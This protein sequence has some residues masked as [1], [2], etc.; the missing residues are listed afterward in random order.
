MVARL[1]LAIGVETGLTRVVVQKTSEMTDRTWRLGRRAFLAVAGATAFGTLAAGRALGQSTS[2]GTT[3]D[4]PPPTSVDPIGDLAF[5]LDADID[6]IFRFVADEIRYEPYAG[7]LRG[8]KGTLASRAG[9]SVDQ[10]L[11]LAALLDA[12]QAQVR[13][14]SGKIDEPTAATL[15]GT[16]TTGAEAARMDV[17]ERLL[18]P[19]DQ[20]ATVS[21]DPSITSLF[22]M[23]APGLVRENSCLMRQILPVLPLN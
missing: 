3:T 20:A 18:G 17:A 12:A 2:P 4:F 9:N 16:S 19:R 1:A 10:A 11:L 13:F 14:A 7:A 23:P 21:P 5:A 22:T 15:L 6:R 8:A